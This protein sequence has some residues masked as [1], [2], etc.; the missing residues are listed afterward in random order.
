MI[1]NILFLDDEKDIVF[2]FERTF[3][4][5]FNITTATSAAEA[6]DIIKKSPP[7]AA[8]I[9]DYNM[10][11][12]NGMQF[13]AEVKNI[14]PNSV[15]IMLTG[16][17]DFDTVMDAVNENNIYKFLLKPVPTE[18][19]KEQID[20]AVEFYRL[21]TFER[22][23]N[24]LKAGFLSIVS[25]NYKTPLTAILTS[26][27]LLNKYYLDQDA[28]NF[29]STIRKIQESIKSMSDLIEKI[30]SLN[31]LET[32]YKGQSQNVNIIDLLKEYIQEYEYYEKNGHIFINKF[33]NDTIN[34]NIDSTLF[35]IIIKNVIDNAIKFSP[36]RTQI[37][38]QTT[39]TKGGKIEIIIQ[40]YGSGIPSDIKEQI[41][42]PFV[43]SSQVFNNESI[44]LGLSIAKKALDLLKG[45]IEIESEIN[46]GTKV[47]IVI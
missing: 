34:Q 10:P 19:L 40:D 7:F 28:K 29:D 22:E 31:S 3:R 1:P 23:T 24:Q 41:F 38:V 45:N 11:K 47:K 4:R 17:A 12:M 26:T 5:Y 37:V 20:E 8:I 39:M 46:I 2:T 42:S 32:S 21:R 6:L 15:R 27:Y 33:E 14:S 18:V 9:S 43:K 44:G 25:H 16:H 30:S 36:P 13:L 35:S